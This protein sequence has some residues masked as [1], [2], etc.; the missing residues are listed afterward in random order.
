MKARVWLLV[1][2]ILAICVV[3]CSFASA[4]NNTTELIKIVQ[5]AENGAREKAKIG[6]ISSNVADI[7]LNKSNIMS[8]RTGPTITTISAVTVKGGDDAKETPIPSALQRPTNLVVEFDG[9]FPATGF[10]HFSIVP[11][12]QKKGA[13]NGCND[14]ISLVTVPIGMS[15]RICEHDG[16]GSSGWGLCRDFGA[17]TSYVGNDLND[18]GTTFGLLTKEVIFTLQLRTM[19]FHQR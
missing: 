15:A 2:N 8:A 7:V 17:G 11:D 6:K 18:Q 5:K 10:C 14:K 19:K 9:D 1:G 12:G 13:P 4:Q 16:Q 3:F